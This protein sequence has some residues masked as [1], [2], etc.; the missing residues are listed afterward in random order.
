MLT[1]RHRDQLKSIE[2]ITGGPG[3]IHLIFDAVASDD[4]KLAK[5]IFESTSSSEKLFTTTNDWSGITDFGGGSTYCIE[6]GVIGRPEGSSLN[7]KLAEYIAACTK[8]M[9]EGKLVAGEHEVVGEGVSAGVEA[10]KYL[11]SGRA[12]SKKVVVKISGEE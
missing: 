9:E 4:P 2:S 1:Q 11:V 6:L 7:T 5:M 12:G 3:K 10:Y 8:L